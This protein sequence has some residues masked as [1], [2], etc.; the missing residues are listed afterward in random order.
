MEPARIGRE[1]RRQLLL[2]AAAAMVAEGDIDDITIERVADRAGVSRALLYKHFADRRD[3]LA[4]VYQRES[5]I[6][7]TEL[8]A[9]VVAADSLEGMFRALIR[10]ALEAQAR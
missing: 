9:A 1:Q 7:H 3:L 2:D 8:T 4:A 6:V 5:Q 10:G